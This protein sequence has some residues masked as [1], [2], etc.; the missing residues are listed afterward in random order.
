MP[1]CVIKTLRVLIVLIKAGWL[2]RVVGAHPS[3]PLLISQTQYFSANLLQL[4]QLPTMGQST[5]TSNE[6]HWSEYRLEFGKYQG[7][8]LVDVPPSYV[9]WLI[10]ENAGAKDPALMAA[11][12]EYQTGSLSSPRPSPISQ[13]PQTE[14]AKQEEIATSQE[15]QSGGAEQDEVTTGGDFVLTFGKHKGKKL[16]EIPTSYLKWLASDVTHKSPGLQAALQDLGM[17]HSRDS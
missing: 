16:S 7:Q 3:S 2:Y 8:K 11:L 17:G 10:K 15:P 14:G 1:V 13:E 4:H 5:S 12:S 6:S 9:A